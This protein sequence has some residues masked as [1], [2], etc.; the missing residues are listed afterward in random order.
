M[1]D[2]SYK[3]PQFTSPFWIPFKTLRSD[4]PIILNRYV[5]YSLIDETKMWNKLK[6]IPKNRKYW[7]EILVIR[8]SLLVRNQF[9]TKIIITS[10]IFVYIEKIFLWSYWLIFKTIICMAFRQRVLKKSLNYIY[11]DFSLLP[12]LTVIDS[13]SNFKPV[14]LI[15]QQHGW[16][17]FQWSYHHLFKLWPMIF[18]KNLELEY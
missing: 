4:W 16:M 8:A 13:F 1:N 2:P 14:K 9:T 6:T 11:H 12:N 5:H 10:I 15:K 17:L 18:P 7:K 3:I